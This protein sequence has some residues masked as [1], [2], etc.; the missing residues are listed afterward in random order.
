MSRAE[1]SPTALPTCRRALLALALALIVAERGVAAQIALAPG[2]PAPATWT[3]PIGGKIGNWYEWKGAP[4]TIVNFWA[5]WCAPCKT[6]MPAL[7]ALRARFAERGLTVHGVVM[8]AAED[9]AVARFVQELSIGY[10]ILRGSPEISELWGGIGRLPTTFLINAE[11]RVVRRYV[12]ATDETV[13]RM[14]AD[15]AALIGEQSK[16]PAAA[17]PPAAPPPKN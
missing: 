9:D 17:S 11:G 1:G 16:P 13:R 6:E 4:L 10:T 7:E 15:V 3:K 14:E 5:T 2:D 8:D 12:G